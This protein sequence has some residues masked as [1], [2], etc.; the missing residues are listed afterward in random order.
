MVVGSAAIFAP[1]S[2]QGPAEGQKEG[3]VPPKSA[4]E[5]S[6][7][8]LPIIKDIAVPSPV[9]SPMVIPTV[10]GTPPAPE[11]PAPPQKEMT[12]SWKRDLD[13]GPAP[14]PSTPEEF[15]RKRLQGRWRVTAATGNLLGKQE[16]CTWEFA[17][18]N[19]LIRDG[20]S[21]LDSFCNLEL[22]AQ[23]RICH[24]SVLGQR[25]DATYALLDSDTLVLRL[26]RE[27]TTANSV[28]VLA[29]DEPP[30]P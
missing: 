22:C 9:P 24:F 6:Q 8:P 10:V 23:K 16:R 20:Y 30:Q 7:D 1:L 11:P 17:G 26:S 14:T 2:G 29:R 25:W 15:E 21:T 13:G 19:L 12:A 18:G 5:P 28:I 4:P 3:P 27:E